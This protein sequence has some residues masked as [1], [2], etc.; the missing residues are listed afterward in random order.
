ML[1]EHNKT[2]YSIIMP[3]LKLWNNFIIIEKKKKVFVFNGKKKLM[4]KI[5]K[6][7]NKM[8]LRLPKF[9]VLM[10]ILLAKRNQHSAFLSHGPFCVNTA[11]SAVLTLLC[12]L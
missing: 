1:N 2:Y 12:T 11:P 4:G 10:Y 5:Q 6:E 3:D 7:E 9:S 8:I